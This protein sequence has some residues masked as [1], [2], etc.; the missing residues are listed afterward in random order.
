MKN[1]KSLILQ[2]IIAILGTIAGLITVIA[3]NQHVLMN[4]SLLLRIIFMIVSYWLI[5]IVPMIIMFLA[6]DSL[7]DYG[8]TKD[9]LIQQIGIGI[10]IALC[11]SF[12]FTV[13]PHLAGKGDW[14]NNG[15]DY[16]FLWQFLYDFLYYILA[17]ALVEE[18]IFRGFLLQ[19]LKQIT[20]SSLV[21][22]L[23]SSILFGLFHLASGNIIQLFTTTILGI[24]LALC[25]ERIKNC[26]L[27]SV[28]IAHGVYDA[29]ITVWLWVF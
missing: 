20:N 15:H 2:T 27:L 18:F 12:L 16:E 13:L 17:I 6:K 26:T 7:K 11:L 28:I 9:H 24:I 25:K 23:G 3:F 22:I 1:H 4:M 8:F 5:A 21:A 19:K 10:L 29:L 14:V